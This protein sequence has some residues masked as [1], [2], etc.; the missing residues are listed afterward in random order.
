MKPIKIRFPDAGNYSREELELNPEKA[1]HI[2]ENAK[3]M[4]P[5]CLCTQQGVPMYIAFRHTYYLAR[6][7]NT[8]PVHAPYCPSYEPDPSLSG[9]GIYSKKAVVERP[10]GLVSVKLS[11]ALN[12]RSTE[13]T[14]DPVPQ[15]SSPTNGLRRE[16]KDSLKLTGLLHLLW[17]QAQFNRWSPKMKGRRHYRQI[18]KF[19]YE[20]ADG[21]FV[22][23]KRLIDHLYIPEPYIKEQSL[24]IERRRGALFRKLTHTAKNEPKRM[25]VIGQVKSF[26]T[27][28]LGYAIR[29]AH[30]PPSLLFWFDDRLFNRLKKTI[31]FAVEDIHDLNEDLK[32]FVAL[33]VEHTKERAWVA[34]E[35]GALVTTADYIPVISFDEDELARRLIE[36]N[37]LF[38]KPMG[39]DDPKTCYPNFLVTDAGDKVLPLEIFG[40]NDSEMANASRND[41]ITEYVTEKD[42]YWFWDVKTSQF[43]PKI[44]PQS[45]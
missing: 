38:Y 10:D 17:E 43:P 24:E 32:I 12:M 39:Y 35:L 16:K 20:A 37:R 23:R 36:S 31:D 22:Q 1:Q 2:L 34:S 7:P 4:T 41:R 9:R 28:E 19:L 42:P 44:K 21:I 29:L 8:G 26:A 14:L 45:N 33:T 3:G 25:I 30:T 11:V 13:N 5:M 18:Y 6:C 40:Q 15:A 27:G